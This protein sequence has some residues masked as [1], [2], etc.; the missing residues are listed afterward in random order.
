[1]PIISRMRLNTRAHTFRVSL[2]PI[3]LPWLQLGPIPWKTYP[4][5]G[6]CCKAFSL[7]Q[8]AALVAMPS[9]DVTRKLSSWH[10]CLFRDTNEN[11]YYSSALVIA[12]IHMLPQ[13]LQLGESREFR[14]RT[15]APVYKDI[16]PKPPPPPPSGQGP[17][18]PHDGSQRDWLDWN[19]REMLRYIM[20]LNTEPPCQTPETWKERQRLRLPDEDLTFVQQTLWRKL[21][22]GTRLVGW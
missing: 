3:Q 11:T 19:N 15:W 13:L 6:M 22:V 1:M 20:T 21:P 18:H 4:F 12:G 8:K 16:V 9:M 17:T 10:S 14:P 5:L 7:L 2:D